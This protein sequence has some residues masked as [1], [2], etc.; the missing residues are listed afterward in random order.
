[1]FR[2][3]LTLQI[4]K[5]PESKQSPLFRYILYSQ[6]SQDALTWTITDPTVVEY[7]IRFKNVHA[8]DKFAVLA[9]CWKDAKG[10]EGGKYNGLRTVVSGIAGNQW[11]DEEIA[12][13]EID[14]LTSTFALF[15]DNS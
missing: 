13:E 10:S 5:V 11:D 1:V 8:S 15:D 12:F 2:R 3:Y 6:T 14:I 7:R 4:T 9:S